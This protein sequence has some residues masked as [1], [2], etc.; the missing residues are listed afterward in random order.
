[1]AARDEQGEG[2]AQE[3]MKMKEGLEK[4]TGTSAGQAQ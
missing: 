2:P 1:M 3:E 4:N